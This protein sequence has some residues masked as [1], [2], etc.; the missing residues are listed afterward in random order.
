[1]SRRRATLIWFGLALLAGC[2]GAVKGPATYPVTGAVM[3]G[4]KP[5]ADALVEFTPASASAEGGISAGMAGAQA[6]TDADGKY[7]M[8]TM[9]AQGKTT[10][11]GLAAGDYVVTVRKME[12]PGG[13]ASATRPPKNVLPAKYASTNS[14]PL[15]A[16]VKAD[17]EKTFDFAL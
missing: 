3:M 6:Q 10:V 12:F 11:P 17:G 2:G 4:G 7:T 5:V 9:L 15:K 8:S 14:S 1:M 13:A 16:T